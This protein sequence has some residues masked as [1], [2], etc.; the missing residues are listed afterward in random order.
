MS[1]DDARDAGCPR[2][3]LQQ[4]LDVA[5][6]TRRERLD[7][8]ADARLL[9]D[10]SLRRLKDEVAERRVAPLLAALQRRYR[11]TAEEG[12]ER[13]FAKHLAGLGPAEQERVREW[14][15]TL[16]RRFAHIPSLGLRGLARE[17]GPD[18]VEAFLSGLDD[19]LASALRREGARPKP[20]APSPG[21]RTD[22]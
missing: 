4:V 20:P 1:P 15:V 12:I 7:E 22:A 10:A 2:I 9:V 3:G 18:G 13:L 6:E 17:A 11:R 16:A 5:A 21:V 8:L 19:A 14:A